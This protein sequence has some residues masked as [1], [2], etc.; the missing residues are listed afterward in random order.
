MNIESYDLNVI[1]CVNN[2]FNECFFL[3]HKKS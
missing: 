3:D 1:L 2:N